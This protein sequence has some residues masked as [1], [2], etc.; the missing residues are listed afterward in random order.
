MNVQYLS[1]NRNKSAAALYRY[2]QCVSR[3]IS[4][5]IF[6]MSALSACRCWITR[7][8]L[9]LFCFP[10]VSPSSVVAPTYS[11]SS[12]PPFISPS[13]SLIPIPSIDSD[14]FA[15]PCTQSDGLEILEPRSYQCGGERQGAWCWRVHPRRMG[16]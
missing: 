5:Y 2:L 16:T 11:F 14:S 8:R 12:P 10:C 6:S 9:S 7:A 13:P 15:P 4:G 1:T 3:A